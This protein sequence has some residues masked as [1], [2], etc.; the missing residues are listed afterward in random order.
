[1]SLRTKLLAAVIGLHGAFLLLALY[2]LVR[3]EQ[4]TPDPSRDLR[5]LASEIDGARSPEDRERA[6]ARLLEM[7]RAR[8]VADV[9][10]VEATERGPRAVTHRVFAATDALAGTRTPIDPEG[11]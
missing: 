7:Q 6:R 1:M 3:E 8:L 4:A 2:W 5:L 9:Y 11:D 10:L